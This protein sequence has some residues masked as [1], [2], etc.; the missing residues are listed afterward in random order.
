MDS[1]TGTVALVG[2][3]IALLVATATTKRK[4]D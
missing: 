1:R 4:D 3:S 2:M